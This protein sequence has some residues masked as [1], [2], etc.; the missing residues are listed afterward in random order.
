MKTL[1][2]ITSALAM[3]AALGLSTAQAG[4]SGGYGQPSFGANNG[5]NASVKQNGNGCRNRCYGGQTFNAGVNNG[6]NFGGNGASGNN[7]NFNGNNANVK[8]NGNGCRNRCFGGQNFN[9]GVNNGNNF[10]G[11]GKH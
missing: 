2:A 7:G 4:G 9:A 1:L 5:N 11:P 6:N 10:G 3:T 8:Q